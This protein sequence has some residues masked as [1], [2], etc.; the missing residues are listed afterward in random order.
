MILFPLRSTN[1][2]EKTAQ[3]YQMAEKTQDAMRMLIWTMISQPPCPNTPIL[4]PRFGSMAG[5]CVLASA[6]FFAGVR[7]REFHL[8][9]NKGVETREF[10][11]H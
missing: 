4:T 1:W 5:F 8:A 2:F 6:L 11:Q 7:T 9:P 3:L 10:W